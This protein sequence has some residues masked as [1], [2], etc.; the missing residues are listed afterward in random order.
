[1]TSCHKSWIPFAFKGLDKRGSTSGLQKFNLSTIN[2]TVALTAPPPPY[3][4]TARTRTCFSFLNA[5]DGIEGPHFACVAATLHLFARRR[6]RLDSVGRRIQSPT[7]ADPKTSSRLIATPSVG[8]LF[9]STSA[10]SRLRPLQ[11]PNPP[12]MTSASGRPQFSCSSRL[13]LECLQTPFGF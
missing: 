1:M 7:A 11:T 4:L 2:P 3:A 9:T 6:K 5:S 8:D 10:W 13:S 12:A